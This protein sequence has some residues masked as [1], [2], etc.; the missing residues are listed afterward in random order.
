MLVSYQEKFTACSISYISTLLASKYSIGLFAHFKE[1]FL[2][3]TSHKLNRTYSK[4]SYAR[5][6][7]TN[8]TVLILTKNLK[9]TRNCE[10]D[11]TAI[12]LMGVQC[13]TWTASVPFRP[14]GKRASFSPVCKSHMTRP[15]SFD[16]EKMYLASAVRARQVKVCLWH[17]WSRKTRVVLEYIKV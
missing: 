9:L 11:E 10:S 17:L 12:A 5:G 13:P 4:M 3:V 6:T 16:P 2:S 14:P 15:E 7:K 1:T 8:K